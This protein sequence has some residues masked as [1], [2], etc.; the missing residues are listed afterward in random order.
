MLNMECSNEMYDK[1]V[2]RR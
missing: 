2:P 1:K